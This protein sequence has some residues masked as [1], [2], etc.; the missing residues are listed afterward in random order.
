M[1]RSVTFF[2]PHLDGAFS[3]DDEK[4]GTGNRAYCQR[5][6]GP[7]A[8]AFALPRTRSTGRF[9]K[10]CCLQMQVTAHAGGPVT[11]RADQ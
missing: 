10:L 1:S 6:A 5:I 3:S 2:L 8:A 7:M 11:V 9:L 4:A